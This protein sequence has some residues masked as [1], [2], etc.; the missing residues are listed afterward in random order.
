V[1]GKSER[2]SASA[3]GSASK[4]VT[5]YFGNDV[6]GD[7]DKDGRIDNA[8][9]I[10]QETGGSGVFF[11]VVAL[12]DRGNEKVGTEAYFLGDRIAP[13]NSL[14]SDAEELI[15]NFAT[16]KEGESYDVMP[17]IGKSLYLVL[18]PNTLVFVPKVNKK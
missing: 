16:R 5:K 12:L 1:L 8:F 18:D 2:A 17:S 10:T 6:S 13:Q 7:F 9:L 3:P 14:V 4:T 15:I 11:Y